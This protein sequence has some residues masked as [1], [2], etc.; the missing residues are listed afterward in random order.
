MAWVS[1]TQGHAR[2]ISVRGPSAKGEGM[3]PDTVWPIEP[4]TKAKHEIIRRYL[5]A[6]FPI[7]KRFNPTGGLN[8]IDGFAGPG[9]YAGGEDGSPVIALRTAVDHILP[10][11]SLSFDFIEKDRARA[12]RLRS[13]LEE[14]FPNL[15]RNISYE[16]HNGEFAEVMSGILAEFD[17]RKQILAPT[18]TFVDPFGYA[19][20]P[21]G[22]IA[23]LLEPPASDVLIT[24]MASRV[25]RFLDVFHEDALDAL[26]GTGDWRAG[27]SLTG[28]ERVRFLLGLYSRQ[29]RSLTP[30]KHVLSFEMVGRDQNPIYWLV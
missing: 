19:G 18:F 28:N 7:V 24:F 26:F 23:R 3:T 29:I 1:W 21:L 13:V 4:H 9:T 11:P 2:N 22:L 20:V 14:K 25:M 5:G 8:Y 12:V 15:P 16:V 17:A 30:A 27:Q 10:L 6:W